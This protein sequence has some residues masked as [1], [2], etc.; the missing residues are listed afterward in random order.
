MQ[1]KPAK[2]SVF[3][4]VRIKKKP[5]KG[6]VSPSTQIKKKPAKAN[7]SLSRTDHENDSASTNSEKD[8]AVVPRCS[9]TPAVRPAPRVQV[10]MMSNPLYELW[11]AGVDIS[12]VDLRRPIVGLTMSSRPD[13]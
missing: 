13:S 1:K 7:A 11:R 5:A 12:Q 8:T 6:N 10:D 9:A 2:A 3:P 4:S